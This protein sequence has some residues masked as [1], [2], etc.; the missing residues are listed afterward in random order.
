MAATAAVTNHINGAEA[1]A[2]VPAN[3]AARQQQHNGTSPAPHAGK[4][5]QPPQP[6]PLDTDRLRALV[7]DI[8]HSLDSLSNSNHAVGGAGGP[9]GG[10]GQDMAR[11]KLVTAAT[12]LAGAV[13]PPGETIMGW[14]ANMS[15]VS[16]VRVFQHWRVFDILPTGP[17]QAMTFA[18]L[19]AE[20][21]AE[22]SLL[23]MSR[24]P[25]FP[26]SPPSNHDITFF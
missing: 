24:S 11:L 7:N 14:F 6:P 4:Q 21:G 26:P 3:G 25:L 15:V 18:D 13:R 1:T 17:G 2:P 10:G 8:S 19:A 22:E 12:A 5:Q 23:S 9:G 16:A 20:V